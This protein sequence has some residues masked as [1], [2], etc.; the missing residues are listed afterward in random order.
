MERY[1]SGRQPVEEYECFQTYFLFLFH[2]YF[3]FPFSV[4]KYHLYISST[5]IIFNFYFSPL[6][7]KMVRSLTAPNNKDPVY[8]VAWS[9]VGNQVIDRQMERAKKEKGRQSL[10]L[11]F[12]SWHHVTRQGISSSGSKRMYSFIWRFNANKFFQKRNLHCQ[13]VEKICFSFSF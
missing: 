5:K 8:A 2:F 3:Y 9:P 12:F 1:T 7:L 6:F 4:F 13:N 10:I 11:F